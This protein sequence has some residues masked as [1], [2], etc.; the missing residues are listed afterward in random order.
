MRQK[1][2]SYRQSLRHGLV[3]GSGRVEA[4]NIRYCIDYFSAHAERS[5]DQEQPEVGLIARD[6]DHGVGTAEQCANEEGSALPPRR[7]PQVP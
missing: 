4:L 7:V 3:F 6:H 1:M 5:S 2:R